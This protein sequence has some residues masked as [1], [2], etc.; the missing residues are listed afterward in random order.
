MPDYE[1]REQ[2]LWNGLQ[3]MTVLPPDFDTACP[4]CHEA[5]DTSEEA[6]LSIG[7]RFVLARSCRHVFHT[8]CLR[9]W[10]MDQNKQT[11]PSCRHMFYDANPPSG[12]LSV[13]RSQNEIVERIT[14]TSRHYQN[15]ITALQRTVETQEQTMRHLRRALAS[16]IPSASGNGNGHRRENTEHLIQAFAN[17]Y[18]G[19]SFQEPALE[20]SSDTP[21]AGPAAGLSPLVSGAPRQDLTFSTLVP[22]I[23]YV[24]PN[25]TAIGT[26]LEGSL[27]TDPALSPNPYPYLQYGATRSIARPGRQ[28]VQHESTS[29]Q[30]LSRGSTD[31]NGAGAG[32]SLAADRP[33]VGGLFDRPS[34][35]APGTT[36]RPFRGIGSPRYSPISPPM[37]R[38]SQTSPIMQRTFGG[39]GGLFGNREGGLEASSSGL[40]ERALGGSS[41]L[42]GQGPQAAPSLGQPSSMGLFG[43]ARPSEASFGQSQQREPSAGPPPAATSPIGTTNGGTPSIDPRTQ[44][45]QSLEAVDYDPLFHSAA[46]P[47]YSAISREEFEYM[48][49]I[50][51]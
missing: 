21:S 9:K 36:Q 39:S 32:P 40:G 13:M 25:L 27:L 30:T 29:D 45:W 51:R 4:I 5:Y 35:S 24:F 46:T 42:S 31:S 7:K 2:F 47:E 50:R 34:E 12:I 14:E 48:V 37:Q 41:G 3:Q 19:W 20:P 26:G 16:T 38:T 22:S 6:S 28:Q 17:R 23:Q 33:T 15:T 10:L 18:S 43:T 1:T 11:C 49:G 44:F 8:E